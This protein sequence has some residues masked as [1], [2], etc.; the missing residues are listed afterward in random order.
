MVVN[1]SQRR[2]KS[3]NKIVREDENRKV[4]VREDPNRRKDNM[5][6]E[7]K[8]IEPTPEEVKPTE[9]EVDYK[10]LYEQTKAENERLRSS[11]TKASADVSRYKKELSSV[12]SKEELARRE[13]EEEEERI[14]EELKGYKDRERIRN[15]SDKYREAGFSAETANKMAELLPESVSDEYFESLKTS[16]NETVERLKA[17]ALNNQPKPTT[18][19][20]PTPKDL[21]KSDEDKLLDQMLKGAGLI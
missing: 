13:R 3:Q 17:E 10:A 18:G 8:V 16:Y 11:N 19:T 21:G 15:Y 2:R 1:T 9:P 12:L 5:E 20:P 7:N 4:M 6:D 14:R